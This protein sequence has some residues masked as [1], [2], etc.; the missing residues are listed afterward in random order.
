MATL[1]E[2]TSVLA[3]ILSDISDDSDKNFI[4]MLSANE[5]QQCN[6]NEITLAALQLC[7]QQQIS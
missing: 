3:A 6:N 4:Y 5:C 1:I 2:H 7:P